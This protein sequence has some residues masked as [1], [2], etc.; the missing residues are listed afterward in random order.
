[1]FLALQGV[2]I[3]RPVLRNSMG[4]FLYFPSAISVFFQR[5]FRFVFVLFFQFCG[6]QYL[7]L[8]S[9]KITLIRTDSRV[10]FQVY[11]QISF[12]FNSQIQQSG[13]S[14]AFYHCKSSSSKPSFYIITSNFHNEPR[15]SP[16][17]QPASQEIPC[18]E[19]SQFVCG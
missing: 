12:S 7:K 11:G 19:R 18:V 4:K 15:L 17:S 13:Y 16:A 3:D 2:V 14:E 6:L 10:G 5:F 8:V 9:L 1:M